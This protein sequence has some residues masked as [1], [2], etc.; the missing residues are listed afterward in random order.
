MSHTPQPHRWPWRAQRPLKH[1]LTSAPRLA[2]QTALGPGPGDT[3]THHQQLQ[4]CSLCWV[5]NET[6]G[7]EDTEV[8][9]EPRLRRRW[10]A[11]HFTSLFKFWV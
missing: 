2:A 4:I 11:H 9:Q 1:T 3:T 5:L 8:T 6:G 10:T 7:G